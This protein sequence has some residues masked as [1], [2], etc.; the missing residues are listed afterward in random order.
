MSLLQSG[1]G[2]FFLRESHAKN[3]EKREKVKDAKNG[4]SRE[5]LFAFK[6]SDTFRQSS[7]EAFERE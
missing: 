3:H 1:V 4:E 2:A 5:R 7:C 6:A